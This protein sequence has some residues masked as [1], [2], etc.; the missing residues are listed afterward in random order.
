MSALIKKTNE[1]ITAAYEYVFSTDSLKFF[2]LLLNTKNNK[3][4]INKKTVLGIEFSVI[5]G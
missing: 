1:K 3:G 2:I 5:F 4:I